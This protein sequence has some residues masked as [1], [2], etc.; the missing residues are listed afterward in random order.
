VLPRRARGR[1]SSDDLF[2]ARLRQL[3]PS[4]IDGG[5]GEEDR[6]RTRLAGERNEPMNRA[7]PAIVHR[8]RLLLPLVFHWMRMAPQRQSV[9]RNHAPRLHRRPDARAVLR[10]FRIAIWLLVLAAVTMTALASNANFPGRSRGHDPGNRLA[11]PPPSP[12]AAARPCRIGA[13]RFR[14]LGFAHAGRPM[15]CPCAAATRPLHYSGRGRPL[16]YLNWSRIPERFPV[17]WASTDPPN[18]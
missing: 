16:L 13:P 5:F 15:A 2:R 18:R 7:G 17:H 6:E 12:R 14:A 10:R 1:T 8:G 9:R 11:T 4:P 3:V